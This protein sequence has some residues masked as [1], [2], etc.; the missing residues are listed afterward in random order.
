MMLEPYRRYAREQKELK[1]LRSE[2]PK[3]AFNYDTLHCYVLI[4][5]I[6]NHRHLMIDTFQEAV[7][8]LEIKEGKYLPMTVAKNL[9]MN[10]RFPV[11]VELNENGKPQ[12]SAIRHARERI[13]SNGR[14]VY[15]HVRHDGHCTQNAFSMLH[16]HI[17]CMADFNAAW[18]KASSK[19]YTLL[20]KK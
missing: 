4:I 10:E 5:D 1:R 15:G 20:C 16:G 17:T 11:V 9:I 12:P 7:S 8:G 19:S 2:A 6:V 18:E 14:L 3:P 13:A